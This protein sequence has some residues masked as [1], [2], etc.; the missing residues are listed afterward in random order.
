MLAGR[1]AWPVDS[2]VFDVLNNV[3]WPSTWGVR[4]DDV[5]SAEATARWHLNRVPRMVPFFSH[6]YLPA[7]PAIDP[8]VY[9]IYQTDVIYYGDNLLDYVAH[10]FGSGPRHPGGVT[11]SRTPF[12]SDLAEGEEDILETF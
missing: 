6:R 2:I 3:F 12:W 9:S 5:V 10:E 11:R 4:P 7:A 8:P 1:L